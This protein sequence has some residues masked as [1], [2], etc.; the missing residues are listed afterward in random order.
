[1]CQG[2]DD[3]H[4]VLNNNLGNAALGNLFQKIDGIVGIGTRHAR[5]RLV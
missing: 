3:M 5:C 4:V 2:K 1:M